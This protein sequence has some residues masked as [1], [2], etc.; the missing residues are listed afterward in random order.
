MD[1]IENKYESNAFLASIFSLAFLS[2]SANSSD[3]LIN[4]SI[5]SYDNL[6]LSLVMVI[7]SYLPVPLS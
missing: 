3:S 2:S 6:P 7:L 5:S 1:L 4:L